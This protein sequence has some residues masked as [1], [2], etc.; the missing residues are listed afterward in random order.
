MLIFTIFRWKNLIEWCCPWSLQLHRQH[1]ET[2]INFLLTTNRKFQEIE[3]EGTLNDENIAVVRRHGFDVVAL[4]FNEF[5][6]DSF[7]EL[8]EILKCVP[9]LKQLTTFKTLISMTDADVPTQMDL[10]EL[11]K[12]KTLQMARTQ[13]RILK[14]LG[15]AKLTTIKVLNSTLH[16]SYDCSDLEQFLKSQDM[17]TTLAIRSVYP[18]SSMLFRTQNLNASMPFQLTKLSLLY[19]QLGSPD[20]Y[21]NLLKFLEPQAKS[22]KELELGH[23]FPRSVY[24]FVFAKMANLKTL[25]LMLG[26]IP[27]EKEL[28]ERMVANRSITNLICKDSPRYTNDSEQFFRY[29]LKCLPNVTSLTLLEECCIEFVKAIAHSFKNLKVLQTSGSSDFDDVQFANLNALKIEFQLDESFDWDKFTKANPQLTELT[30][31]HFDSLDETCLNLTDI[32]NITAN[33]KLHTLRL[34]DGFV[35]DKR[36]FEI[37]RKN[38]PTLKTLELHQSCGL[39]NE[40]RDHADLVGVVRFSQEDF[41]FDQNYSTFWSGGLYEDEDVW[42]EGADVLDPFDIHMMDADMMEDYEDDDDDDEEDERYDDDDNDGFLG[43]HY[44]EFGDDFV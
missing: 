18:N 3:L 35:A 20:D 1:D 44:N 39:W 5:R 17:L 40:L 42:D 4:S 27:Q 14:C 8:T 7:A 32:E 37:I 33:N 34:G 16:Y 25:N 15:K 30:I 43:Y 2:R 19:I 23:R 10:P 26:D 21:N 12:L 9:N 38:C 31:N 29:F 41:V 22:M 24:E 13:Y 28:L 36:F 6:F 11:T